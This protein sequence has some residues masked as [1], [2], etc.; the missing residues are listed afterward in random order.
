MP[1]EIT[2][3]RE[4]LIQIEKHFP[5]KELLTKRDVCK[6]VGK[7]YNTVRKYYPELWSDKNSPGILKTDLAQLMAK[8]GLRI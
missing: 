8:K 3:T 2:G 7:A 5:D 1:R 4:C 6:V